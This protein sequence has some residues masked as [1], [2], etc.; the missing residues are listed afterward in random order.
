MNARSLAAALLL[1]ATAA[2]MPAYAEDT[3]VIT[4]RPVPAAAK[5]RESVSRPGLLTGLYASYAGL[6]AYDVYSTIPRARPCRAG[7]AKRIR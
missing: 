7:R 4:G 3:I 6:Q 2:A 1:T 5:G